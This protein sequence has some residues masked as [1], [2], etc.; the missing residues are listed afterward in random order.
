MH[1]NTQA[2]SHEKA[3]WNGGS[4]PLGQLMWGSAE[5]MVLPVSVQLMRHKLLIYSHGL[6]L[7][8]LWLPQ[9]QRWEMFPQGGFCT[10]CS[11]SDQEGWLSPH[12]LRAGGIWHGPTLGW[13]P[14]P[15][16]QPCT[17]PWWEELDRMDMEG[18]QCVGRTGS[19]ILLPS[20]R[21]L[22]PRVGKDLGPSVV[23]KQFRDKGNCHSR[24]HCHL[25]LGDKGCRATLCTLGM[26]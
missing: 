9:I 22:L 16:P 13:V 2:G 19:D 21:S 12:L 11:W 5:P 25:S 18:T 3:A 15:A 7:K 1:P 8:P 23:C 26:V 24:P 20:E 4:V 6:L 14:T 17:T 10:Q